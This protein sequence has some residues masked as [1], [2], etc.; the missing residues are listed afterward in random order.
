MCVCG[1]GGML[2]WQLAKMK[3]WGPLESELTSVCGLSHFS[4]VWLF[5]TPWTAA[6]QAPLSLGF[7]R[8]EYWSGLPCPPLRGLPDPGVVLM[9]LKSLA[10]ASGFLT[11]SATWEAPELMRQRLHEDRA[12]WFPPSPE[13]LSVEEVINKWL[14]INQWANGSALVWISWVPLWPYWKVLE[15]STRRD[16]FGIMAPS[17]WVQCFQPQFFLLLLLLLFFFFDFFKILDYSSFQCYISL[18][19]TAKWF[20]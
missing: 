15:G 4:R 17:M 10:F 18:R 11:S 1:G 16:G 19:C 8:Q 20:S 6:H 7:S 2:E 3:A 5:V 9:S 12:C 13:M 14:G